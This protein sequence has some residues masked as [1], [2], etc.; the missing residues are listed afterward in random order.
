MAAKLPIYDSLPWYKQFWPWLLIA[1]PGSVVIAGLTTLYIANKYSDDL[2]ADNYYKEGL[3]INR[4][5]EK[6]QRAEELGLQAE[7]SISDKGGVQWIEIR[8]DGTPDKGDLQLSLSHPLEADRDFVV[9]LVQG[10]PGLYMG[11]LPH[12]VATRWHWTLEPSGP[13]P[14]RLD[15]TIESGDL[16]NEPQ[17]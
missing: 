16:S 10:D 8:I 7:F 9:H 13:N 5:L 2:V 11:E 6:N 14:W 3:A 17:Q 4:Q 1:L 12:R 15:G